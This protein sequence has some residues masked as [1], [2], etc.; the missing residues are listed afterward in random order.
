MDTW[1]GV[2]IQSDDT[3]FRSKRAMS[4]M[5][6]QENDEHKLISW[7]MYRMPS[8]VQASVSGFAEDRYAAAR[9]QNREK[10]EA[11]F[12][13]YECRCCPY[14]ALHE[15]PGNDFWTGSEYETCSTVSPRHR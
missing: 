13:K 2:L 9:S 6:L 12:A 14:P 8:T 5:S 7:D 11:I 1:I 10:V 15:L 3:M 4:T